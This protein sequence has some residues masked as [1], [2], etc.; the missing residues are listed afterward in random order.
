MAS[1]P[2]CLWPCEVGPGPSESSVVRFP[3]WVS[4][5]PQGLVGPTFCLPHGMHGQ[6]STRRGTAWPP[7]KVNEVTRKLLL[8]AQLC[9][10]LPSPASPQQA[11]LMLPRTPCLSPSLGPENVLSEPRDL[12][13]LS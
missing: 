1:C 10:W 9:E 6:A 2:A 4:Q 12:D 13:R 3:W 7:A 11:A 8:G 5:A